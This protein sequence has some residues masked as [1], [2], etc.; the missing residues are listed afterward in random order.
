MSAPP[1]KAPAEPLR[2]LP[3]PVEVSFGRTLL[4]FFV[5]PLLVVALGVGI[6]LGFAWLVSDDTTNADYLERIRA[7]GHRER[8]QAAFELANRIQH[9][10]P[11]EFQALGPELVRVFEAAPPQDESWV[12]QYL[13]LALGNLQEEAAVPALGEALGDPDATVRVYAA[14]ALGAIGGDDAVS[15]LAGASRAQD[16]G[17]RTMAVYGL[18]AIGDPAAR[19]PLLRAL[20]DPVLDVSVNAVVALARLGDE[21][22]TERLLGMMEPSWWEGV[23]DMLAGERTVARL[24][25]VRAARG[26]DS[27]AVRAQ[28]GEVAANDADLVVR[29]AALAALEDGERAPDPPGE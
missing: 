28:L 15:A 16:A 23:P 21:A 5:I 25:A 19:E 8:R 12:R 24:S 2:D 20:E 14:W 11:G 10:A 26:L 6:F 9:G 18:G 3:D 7:G 1:E 22:A 4:Q 13:A 29:E 17:L 27:P